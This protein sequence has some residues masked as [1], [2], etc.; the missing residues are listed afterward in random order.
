MMNKY[1][2]IVKVRPGKQR[3]DNRG[4][5]LLLTLLVTIILAIVVLE[6]NYLIRVHA[7][8]SGHLVD[9]LKAEAAARAGVEMAKA[10]LLNDLLADSEKGLT[11]DSFDEEWA[12][13]IIVETHSATAEAIVSDEMSKLN[14]NRL[15]NRTVGE[16]DIENVNKTMAD[17]VRRLF[18][19]LELDPN[20]VDGIIDWLDENDEDEPFGA[21]SSYYESLD[22]PLRCKNG[23]LDNV[24]ELLL[25][26]DFDAEILYGVEDEPGL[27]EFVTVGGDKKGRININT[28]A[29]EI[30]GAVLDDESLAATI[31]SMRDVEPFVS[32]EDMATRIA[33]AN[34]LKKFTTDSSF[35]SVSSTGRIASE[36]ETARSVTIKALLKRVKGEEGSENDYFGIDTAY[37]KMER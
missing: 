11:S 8:L 13:E 29:E 5:A 36:S 7:T 3:S 1:P 16:I 9:N 33:G 20:L 25:I 34:I 4:M 2:I 32:A 21:E 22:P 18:E 28:A 19:S 12:A 27:V 26:K 6:F 14:L 31:V 17:N 24:D 15:L 37:W 30:V 35:F 10:A 23:P